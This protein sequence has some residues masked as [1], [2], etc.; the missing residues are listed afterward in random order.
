[1]ALPAIAARRRAALLLSP[2]NLAPLAWPRNVVVI[3]DVAALREP[4]WYSR[5]Y[6]AWQRRILPALAKRAVRVVA[7]SGFARGEIVALLGAD[8][9][10]VTVVPGGVGEEFNPD[11]DPEPARRALALGR[12][13]VLTVATRG[14]RKNLAALEPIARALAEV[15]LEVAVAGGGRGYLP[16]ASLPPGIRSLGYVP[17]DQLPG[18]Y[19]GAA[20]LVLPSLY[21]GFGLPCLEAMACGTPV[22]AADRA[23]L[24]EACGG[25]ALLVDPGDEDA[26]TAAVVR[27]AS[28]AREHARLR[29]AGLAR[30]AKV[31]WSRTARELDGLLSELA[32]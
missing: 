26:L 9:A 18:L 16:A 22:V 11:A 13:Y 29:D 32:G 30:A 20:A 14:A 25:A 4:R 17:E 10:R 3:H 19:A 12:P 6:V 23:A 7:P 15:G 5:G 24:P 27:A 31:P 28:D 8:P 2:A 1:V 21:E